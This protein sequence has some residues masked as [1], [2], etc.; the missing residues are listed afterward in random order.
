MAKQPLSKEERQ[1][2]LEIKLKSIG[3]LDKIVKGDG[4]DA[5]H[6]DYIPLGILRLSVKWATCLVL[7]WAI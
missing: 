5:R 6:K 2:L 7:L 4:F 1:K 3:S